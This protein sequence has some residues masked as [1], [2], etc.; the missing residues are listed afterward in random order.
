MRSFRNAAEDFLPEALG[1]LIAAHPDAVWDEAGFVARRSPLVTA[2]GAPAVALVSGGGSGH[3]PMHAGFVGAGMLA[4]ACPGLLFTSPNAVQVTEATRWADQGRGVLHVVKNY[5]GDVMNFRVARQALSDVETAEVIVDDDVATDMAGGNSDS[6]SDGGPGRRGTA[7]TILV[8]KIAGAAAH[9]GDDLAA[10]ARIAQSVADNSRS[11]SV[12]LAPGHL[13]TSGRDTFDLD[14][15]EMELGVG[16][17]GERGVSRV[18]A[19]GADAVCEHLLEE[20]TAALGLG[21]GEE[22]FCLV[23]GLGGT[24]ALELDLLF[25]RAA[26]WLGERGIQVRRSLVGS[27][28]TSVNMAGASITLTRVL[29][30]FLEL[31]DAET[32]APAWPRALGGPLDPANPPTPARIAFA[33]GLS[34]DAA[35]RDGEECAWLGAFVERVQG[36]VDKLTELDRLAGDGDFGANMDAALGDIALPMRGT[37]AELA[38]ALSHRFLVRAGG[39]SGAVLGTAFREIAAGLGNNPG[40]AGLA[41]GLENA[42]S[43]VMDLGGAQE[44]DRTLLDALAPAARAAR[45]AA[46]RGDGFDEALTAAHDAAEAGA[47]A[48]R[49]LVARKGRASYVG[50][51]AR[52]VP[53][54]GAIVLAWI[55]GGSGKVADFRD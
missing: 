16:I 48:T 50:D 20:I 19:E 30:D 40:A 17:H 5:T 27:F 44:G 28:V 45:E 26:G 10:V 2:D 34:R 35:P 14:A 54:P 11:M 38:D 49:E 36:A 8:E 23:N 4:A 39:T 53:D 21:E 32:A 22:V 3:E 1:G 12:A 18:A 25:G 7:A 31:L 15:G 42:A 51:A 33:D 41:G 47:L 6:D 46:D 9:R 43:A 52:G 24:T 37:D 29:P 13:P 55:F